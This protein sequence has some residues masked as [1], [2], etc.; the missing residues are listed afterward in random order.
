LQQITQTSSPQLVIEKFQFWFQC[1]INPQ[2]VKESNWQNEIHRPHASLLASA[3]LSPCHAASHHLVDYL[4]EGRARCPGS[5]QFLRPLRYA[6]E[7]R[8][9]PL[10]PPF[11]RK[12]GRIYVLAFLG[13]VT[14]GAGLHLPGN[15]DYSGHSFALTPTGYRH[16]GRSSHR[17]TCQMICHRGCPGCAFSRDLPG[18]E[19]KF[20]ELP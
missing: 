4:L 13:Q 2:F 20:V 14:T 19:T 12:H 17:W 6:L 3:P 5:S 15:I 10:R 16:Y 7:M 18:T 11:C 8:S 9:R 1:R